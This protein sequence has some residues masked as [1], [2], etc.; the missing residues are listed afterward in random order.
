MIENLQDLSI[1]QPYLQ[2]L[3]LFVAIIS[4]VVALV[5]Y[6]K[7]RKKQR[8]EKAM[9]LAKY[10]KDEFLWKYQ[11]FTLYIEESE[12]SKRLLKLISEKEISDFTQEEM[13]EIVEKNF[14]KK[15]YSNKEEALNKLKDTLFKCD[16]EL[17]E[18]I[19]VRFEQLKEENIQILEKRIFDEAI[20]CLNNLEW[21]AMNFTTK[22]ANDKCVYQSLHQTYIDTVRCCYFFI[23]SINVDWTEK[24]FTHLIALYNKWIKKKAKQA[25]KIEKKQNR[26][27]KITDLI[28]KRKVIKYRIPKY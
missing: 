14:Q 13:K 12:H 11:L 1:L 8:I 27:D 9:E 26:G 18:I 23:A 3:M 21:F 20:S 2:I 10:Y 28:S 4:A 22:L 16:K 25:K 24:Y 19:F 6:L 15:G 5:T 7:G 17:L